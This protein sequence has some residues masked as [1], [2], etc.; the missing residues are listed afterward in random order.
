ML[1]STTSSIVLSLGLDCASSWASSASCEARK[2]F[3]ITVVIVAIIDLIIPMS[4]VLVLG[5]DSLLVFV[6]MRLNYNM[7]SSLE[8]GCG[9]PEPRKVPF[10]AAFG[11]GCE[12]L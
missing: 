4:I 1:S 2:L 6:R 3:N 11:G 9:A 10:A 7:S 8:V 5:A 12:L